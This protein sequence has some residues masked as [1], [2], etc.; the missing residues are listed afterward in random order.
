ME[1]VKIERW[2][3]PTGVAFLILGIVVAFDLDE[4]LLVFRLVYSEHFAAAFHP[5]S[6]RVQIAKPRTARFTAP[7]SRT[8]AREQSTN[9]CDV[10]RENQVKNRQIPTCTLNIPLAVF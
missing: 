10:T 2:S 5:S 4:V 6:E 9:E 3:S 7:K 1:K 8:A